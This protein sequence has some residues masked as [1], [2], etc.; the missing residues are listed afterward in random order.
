MKIT[1]GIPA[2]ASFPPETETDYMRFMYYLGRRYQEHE[3]SLAIKRKSEQFRARNAICEEAAKWGA[4]Y[5]LMLDDDQVIDVMDSTKPTEAYEFLRTLIGHLEE[6]PELGLVG[7]VYF[8]RGGECNPV[9]MTEHGSDAYTFWNYTD[10]EGRLQ[11]VDVQGGGCMLIRMKALDKIGYAPFGPEHKYGTDIQIARLM[12]GAGY[13]LACDTSIMLG[14]VTNERIVLTEANRTMYGGSTAPRMKLWL[15]RKAAE[16]KLVKDGMEWLGIDSIELLQRMSSD[17]EDTYPL[18]FRQKYP[19]GKVEQHYIDVSKGMM[20]RHL[21]MIHAY[22]ANKMADTV[23]SSVKVGMAA[24]GIDY[25]CGLGYVGYELARIGHTV[26]F[27]DIPG[28]AY[29]DFIKW[30]AERDGLTKRVVV[31]EMPK[32]ANYVMFL[33]SIEHF[34]DWE[35][36]LEDTC[37]ILINGAILFTN[38]PLVCKVPDKP[39]HIFTDIKAFIAK[40]FEL[41][42]FPINTTIYQKVEHGS[43]GA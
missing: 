16:K 27:I 3:F 8:Q 43:V 40:M 35:R 19:E 7:A 32:K 13:R 18:S 12:R 37:S 38:F 6:D 20:A 15:D 21:L 29:L 42:M 4:D 39:E 23:F 17:Y 24:T 30:R 22:G 28:T 1:I 14:H 5:L 36:V 9:L 26:H 33:D 41:G 34:V 31:N 10:L 25:G 2:Y 11:P